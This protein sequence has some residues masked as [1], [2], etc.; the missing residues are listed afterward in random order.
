MKSI[1]S[2]LLA[3]FILFASPAFCLADPRDSESPFGV[4]D[5]L[6]WDHDWNQ[7]HYDAGKIEKAAKMMK[8]AGGGFIRM[9]FL[10]D[11]IEPKEKEFHFEKYDRIVDILSE[12]QISILGLLS[13]NASWAA[14]EWNAPPHKAYFVNYAQA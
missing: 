9:D 11:D 8:E 1:T 13:Y 4:L 12:N 2:F 3:C 5:F 7:H 10:W 14:S 6:A